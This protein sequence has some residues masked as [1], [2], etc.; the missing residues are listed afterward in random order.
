MTIPTTRQ[1]VIL[2]VVSL[3]GFGLSLF[4]QY[5]TG[6]WLDSLC[7]SRQGRFGHDGDHSVKHNVPLI[8]EGMILK[9]ESR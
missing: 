9:Q 2:V 8:V 6:W 5:V 1:M 3:A 4:L 7:G